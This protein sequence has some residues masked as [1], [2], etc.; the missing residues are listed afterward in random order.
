[1]AKYKKFKSYHLI[2]FIII[3]K[4]V[5]KLKYGKINFVYMRLYISTPV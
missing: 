4:A 5:S 1:M 2:Y 3:Q